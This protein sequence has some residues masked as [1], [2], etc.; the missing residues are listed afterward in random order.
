MLYLWWSLS[1]LLIGFS[2]LLA[3]GQWWAI[4]WVPRTLNAQG[5]PRNYSMIPLLGGLIGTGGCLLAPSSTVQSLW[6]IPLVLDPGCGLLFGHLAVF[7][8]TD[9]V[10]RYFGRK[11]NDD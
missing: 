7:L 6:W 1:I 8:L 2:V 9:A 5:Q 10:K 4:Y 3:V 11:P